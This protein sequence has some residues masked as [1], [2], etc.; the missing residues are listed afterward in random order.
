METFLGAVAYITHRAG[1]ISKE[2][3]T[4][5]MGRLPTC[6]LHR[7]NSATT[8]VDWDQEEKTHLRRAL[9]QSATFPYHTQN[10]AKKEQGFKKHCLL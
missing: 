8:L 4:E 2:Q 5:E 10:S 9:L 6:L 7:T 1:Q 3:Y